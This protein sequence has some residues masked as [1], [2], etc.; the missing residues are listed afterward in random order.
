VRIRS[1][2][3]AA[4]AAFAIAALPAAA[5]AVGWNKEVKSVPGLRI[6]R[7]WVTVNDADKAP[8][9]IFLTPR[10]KLGQRT[11]PTILN[12][13]GKVVWFHRLSPRRT[14]EGLQP[15]VYRG[16]PV[17]VW[18][19]RKPLVHEG[20]SY[21]GDP[22]SVYDVIADTS[23]HVI[24]RIRARGSGVRTDLHEFR[25]TGRNTAL[26][27][28][29]RVVDRD[30]RRYGGIRN[31]AVIDN[32]VQ[33]ID[34][35]TGRLLL[36]FSAMR[37]IS[38]RESYVRPP[39][40]AGGWDAYHLNSITEDSDGNLLVTSRHMSAVYKINRRTGQ[41]M[42]KLGPRGGNFKLSDSARFHYPH[43][44][45]R[46]ADGT[47]TIFDNEAGP[48]TTN[49]ASR[50]LRLRVDSK[51]HTVSLIR[52]FGHP[53]GNVSSTS[54][55]NVSELA[56]KNVFVGWGISPWWSEYA[57]DGRILFA[58]HFKN[59]W[60]QSYRAFKADWHATPKSAPAIY[61]RVTKGNV[62]AYVSWNGATEIATWRL[63]GGPDQ[64]NLT[65]LVEAPW[66]DFETKLGAAGTPAFVKAQALDANGNVLGE[67]GV[68][69]PN[70][71]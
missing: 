36:N 40:T 15:Q 27:L 39:K 16:Q 48:A 67:S 58:A 65:P 55:G 37:R 49:H 10:A 20:D 70:Q 68:V 62:A 52:A 22:H 35:R 46:E 38:P 41:V 69:A 12:A 71:T 64:N 28:G 21:R 24:A 7:V 8:G 9:F 53:A 23:Y 2:A 29:W 4:I 18:G 44:A 13:D 5:Q 17:L 54:Q 60:S 11:G 45:Q 25:I 1:A 42:W 14:A 33:E 57:P 47:I 19:E 50:A 26:L 63:L 43:D 30:L 31:S 3:G 59:P 34:I 32:F 61:A 6:P 66:A 56:N 51:R